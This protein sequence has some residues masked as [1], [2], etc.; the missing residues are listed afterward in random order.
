MGA[1][2]PY[3]TLSAFRLSTL[4]NHFK[5]FVPIRLFVSCLD[6]EAVEASEVV[7][8]AVGLTAIGTRRAHLPKV[9][10]IVGSNLAKAR[11]LWK[12][13]RDGLLAALFAPRNMWIPAPFS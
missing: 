9:P 12:S 7:A 8:A 1:Y 10:R 2:V 5:P 6:V 13:S 11:I 4:I 3:S